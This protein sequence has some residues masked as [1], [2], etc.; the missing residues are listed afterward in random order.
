MDL[1][2]GA[3]DGQGLDHLAAVQVDDVQPLP[4]AATG[5]EHGPG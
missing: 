4:P 2:A 5:V 3:H 1:V